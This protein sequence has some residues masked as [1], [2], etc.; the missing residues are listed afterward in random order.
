MSRPGVQEFLRSLLEALDDLP[1]TLAARL[2]E[3]LNSPHVDRSQALRQ[4]F[5]ELAGD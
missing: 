2:E 4:L 3:L 5:E 1:P